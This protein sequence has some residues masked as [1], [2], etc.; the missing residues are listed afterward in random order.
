[1]G[2]A[3]IYLWD[4]LTFA[5]LFEE[6]KS[7]VL[8]ICKAKIGRFYGLGTRSVMITWLIN[9]LI[10]RQLITEYFENKKHVSVI[11]LTKTDNIC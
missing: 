5:I 11:F 3:C 2:Y 1:M 8:N 10:I 9:W 7:L 6:E 4:C